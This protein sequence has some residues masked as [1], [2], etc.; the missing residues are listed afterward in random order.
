MTS[1]SLLSIV[2]WRTKAISPAWL[3]LAIPFGFVGLMIV[4]IVLE[5]AVGETAVAD[6]LIE[7]PIITIGLAWIWLDLI[8]HQKRL[9]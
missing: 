3:P 5:S 1:A 4:A 8:I 7:I 9:L 2:V 6:R